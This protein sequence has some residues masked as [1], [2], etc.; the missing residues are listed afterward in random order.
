[1]YAIDWQSLGVFTC[2]PALP[3]ARS[4]GRMTDWQSAPSVKLTTQLL[5][6]TAERKKFTNWFFSLFISKLA[7]FQG[8][9]GNF[10]IT[11][12]GPYLSPL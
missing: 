4:E 5:Q 11:W 2:T 8:F 7:I 6:G 1:M 12:S 3:E 10:A 9:T